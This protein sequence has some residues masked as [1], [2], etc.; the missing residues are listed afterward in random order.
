[1]KERLKRVRTPGAGG[2]PPARAVRSVLVLLLGVGLGLLAKWLDELAPDGEI[3]WHRILERLDLGNVFSGL[4]VWLVLALAIAVFSATPLRAALHVFLFFAG[5]CVSYHVYTV[6]F[7]GFDPGG[8]MRIWYGLTLLSPVFAV[9]CWYGKGPS[10][11]SVAIDCLILAVLAAACFSLGFWYFGLNGGVNALLFPAGAAIV[12]S[13][14][15]QSV[16]SVAV[17]LLLAF[18]LRAVLP[19][20]F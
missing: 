8:Y 3:W 11:V 4:A 18:P 2:T 14:P 13:N 9:F 12:Y 16:V 10:P 7:S 20:G 6:V 19:F 5:M 15:R 17:G 1:M